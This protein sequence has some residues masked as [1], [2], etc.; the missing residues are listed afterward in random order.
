MEA[1][2]EYKHNGELHHFE[3]YYLDLE[4]Q[5][6]W[7]DKVQRWLK[8]WKTRGGY[9]CVRLYDTNG[10]H[11]VGIKLS[12]LVWTIA[13]G[14]QIPDGYQV[15]H[16]DE[17]KSNNHP[18]NLEI[19]TC[20]QN[21]NHGTHNARVARANTNGK[22]SKA[23]AQMTLDGQ[24]VR[25]WPSTCEAG[26]NGWNF[27]SVAACCNKC[28]H[29]QGNDVYKGYRWQWLDEYQAAPV[30]ASDGQLLFAF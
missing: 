12:R 30:A 4:T 1:I 24:L 13:N 17:D 14:R 5:R 19:C 29:R 10:K 28:Y 15:N 3:G 11:L 8:T 6:V 16:I 20:K 27:S 25:T 7:S 26:R 23:V 21:I 2:T 9:V 18:S 22:L